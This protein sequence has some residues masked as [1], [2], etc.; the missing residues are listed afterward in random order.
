M[1]PKQPL[2]STNHKSNKRDTKTNTC[3]F[4]KGRSPAEGLDRVLPV[5]SRRFGVVGTT[6][7]LCLDCRRKE[8]AIKS[9]PYPP[10]VE[11]YMDTAYGGRIV[12][13]IN[14]NEARLHYCLKDDQFRNLHHIIVRPVRTSRDPYEVMLYDE[15]AILKQARWVHGGDVGIA[16]ARQF[17]AGQGELVELPPV[18]PVLERRNKIRQAFLMRKVY[19]SSRLPQIRDY[20]K[21][22]RGNFE[23][24][25]DTLAV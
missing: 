22:G 7:I 24:I 9:E 21:T 1:P 8:F 19:A 17:F 10:T 15:K 18:G 6:V 23:E 11:S 16:N 14:E 5:L 25:V 13:R 20:V 2:D 4:C 3:K 12:P